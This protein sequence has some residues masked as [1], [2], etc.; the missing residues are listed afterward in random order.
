MLQD[1]LDALAALTVPGINAHFAIDSLPNRLERAELPALLVLPL[2]VS[3]SR[4]LFRDR[5]EG[6]ESLAF[7]G[8]ERTLTVLVTHLLLVTPVMVDAG[9][10]AQVPRLVTLIDAYFTAL[11]GNI[12]LGDTLR[13][14][15][16]VRVE[17]GEVTYGGVRYIGCNFKHEWVIGL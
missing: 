17:A 5:S 7:S 15:P 16:R 11:G 3:E 14:P 1:A 9:L 2:D 10:G 6:F 4:R 8:G 12:T 13:Q